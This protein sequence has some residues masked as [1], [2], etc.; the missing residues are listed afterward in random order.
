MI[1][2]L[3]GDCGLFE[4]L[5]PR[6]K[7]TITEEYMY[8]R[9]SDTFSI[10]VHV[11]TGATENNGIMA[12][13]DI[14]K[15]SE[16]DVIENDNYIS[17]VARGKAGTMI[18]RNKEHIKKIVLNP[19]VYLLKPRVDFINSK[20]FALKYSKHIQG[21]CSGGDLKLFT[22]DLGISIEIDIPSLEEQLKELPLL[23]RQHQIINNIGILDEKIKNGLGNLISNIPFSKNMSAIDVFDIYSGNNGLTE[24]FIY[25]SLNNIGTKFKVITASTEQGIS[26]GFLTLP[27]SHYR[28]GLKKTEKD[29]KG[30]MKVIIN[31]SGFV[32][33]R[34]GK[35]GL[36]TDILEN[37]HYILNDSAYFISPKKEVVPEK[38]RMDFIYYCSYF[39]AS[40]IKQFSSLTDNGTWAKTNF[41][42]NYTIAIPTDNNEWDFLSSCV[43]KLKQVLKTQDKIKEIIKD[44]SV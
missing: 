18:F 25:Q 35:A 19:N 8:S 39:L 41:E 5:T 6:S 13:V 3:L 7:E 30:K 26:F 31:N 29:D 15:T 20:W 40:D 37:G 33:V 36:I 4:L 44:F 27:E 9:L 34:K 16:M 42:K 14:S 24:D 22:K 32:V 21:K 43:K 28:D 11:L 23:E 10:P 17:I 38:Y 2:Q 12:I 1:Y